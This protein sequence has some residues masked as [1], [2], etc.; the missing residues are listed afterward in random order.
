MNLPAVFPLRSKTTA[1]AIMAV[2]ASTAIVGCRPTGPVTAPARIP[3]AAAPAT[4]TTAVQLI[5]MP[6]SVQIIGA[7]S[8]AI[9]STTAVVIDQGATQDVE[10]VARYLT[11]LLAARAGT[12]PRRLGPGEAAPPGSIRL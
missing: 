8:F 7:E 9:D 4:R 2:L 12:A 1:H 11:E 3:E 6:M 5:P 10:G